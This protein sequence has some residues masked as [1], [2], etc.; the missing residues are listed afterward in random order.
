VFH[1][2]ATTPYIR[3]SRRKVSTLRVLVRAVTVDQFRFSSSSVA[4]IH[5]GFDE[6]TTSRIYGDL[7]NSPDWATD[8]SRRR[9]VP[10]RYRAAHDAAAWLHVM[11]RAVLF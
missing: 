1:I 9:F 7:R 10:G 8:G 2:Q 6:I 4:Y 3:S 11:G 5:L